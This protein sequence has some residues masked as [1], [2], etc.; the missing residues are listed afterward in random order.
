MYKKDVE[1]LI[2][3]R[4]SVRNYDSQQVSEADLEL[5]KTYAKTLENELY[6]YEIID[7]ELGDKEKIGTY[8][9]IKNAKK[10]LVAVGKRSL[11]D[12]QKTSIQFG[13]DFEKIILKATDMGIGTCWMGASYKEDELLG[14]VAGGEDER[15]VMVTPIGYQ[16]GQHMMEKFTRTF[17][18]ADKRKAF[19][20]VF[21][22]DEWLKSLE[23]IEA[24]PYHK[25]LEL[26]RLAPSAGNS[27]PW[28]VIQV[29][30]RYDFYTVPKKFYDKMK[31]QKIRFAM[32]D[33]GI[34]KLHFDLGVDK[35]G[36]QG[37]W[38]EIDQSLQIDDKNYCFSWKKA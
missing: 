2:K 11:V 30:D 14:L 24:N 3:E 19:G 32:N 9:Y 38:I 10:Y 4:K 22:N 18:K 21:F 5:L 26:V 8:G 36:L 17:I 28:R 20:E 7:L 6:R 13:F 12:D 25:V 35:Y 33:L 29:E 16:K 37:K 15:I 27:Q 1:V 23:Y 34:A 31:D